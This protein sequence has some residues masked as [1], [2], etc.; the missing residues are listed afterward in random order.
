MNS[1]YKVR[2]SF[3]KEWQ[4]CKIIDFGLSFSLGK[5]NSVSNCEC[6]LGPCL[7]GHQDIQRSRDFHI[8][9]SRD[10]IENLWI[11]CQE[12]VSMRPWLDSQD[13]VG[14]KIMSLNSNKITHKI[15]LRLNGNMLVTSSI[16]WAFEA[17]WFPDVWSVSY[18]LCSNICVLVWV[19]SYGDMVQ[20]LSS[21][22]PGLGK[23]QA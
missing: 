1:K 23:A 17:L 10:V 12:R 22:G 20:I 8:W 2:I 5:R 7:W 6:W 4:N 3:N 15:L 14:E 18:L 19:N 11:C 9:H 13:D 16:S 21:S